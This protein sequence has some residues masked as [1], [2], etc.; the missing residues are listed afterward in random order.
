M[1]QVNAFQM[2]V[3][4]ELATKLGPKLFRKTVL[5]TGIINYM[6]QQINFD[7]E[8]LNKY[9]ENFNAG[10]KDQVPFVLVDASNRH[11]DLPERYRG[12]IKGLEV[13]ED[14]KHLDAVLEMT[15]SG[16]KLITDNPNL[17]VSIRAVDR[18]ER[19]DGLTFGPTIEHVAGTLDPK[20]NGLGPW[21]PVELSNPTAN[22]I[23]LSGTDE[24][25]TTDEKKES[26]MASLTD[27]QVQKLLGLLE[28]SDEAPDKNKKNKKVTHSEADDDEDE[29]GLESDSATDDELEDVASS[30]D[31]DED[32]NED[33]P[34]LVNASNVDVEALELANARIDAQAVE[35]ARLRTEADR[36][37]Y[38]SERQELWSKFNLPPRIVDLARPLLEGSSNVIE[39]SSGKKVDGGQVIRKV[40]HEFGTLMAR[41]DLSNELGSSQESDEHSEA[42]KAKSREEFLKIAG[43]QLRGNTG[44]AA[45]NGGN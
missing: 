35:L 20:I 15:S 31:A 10:A 8:M 29:Q 5:K 30:V 27:E 23:D 32:E 3:C 39:L 14:G 44:S 24:S 9:V 16:A 2:P 4:I 41:L 25:T 45:R 34:Q 22:V 33:A 37:R 36:T 11:V 12:E 7:T 40:L 6:G 13:S 28:G 43:A 19:P 38:E 18:L 17:G 21:I 42:E 26:L 1:E